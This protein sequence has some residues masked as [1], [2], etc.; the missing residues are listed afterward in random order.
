MFEKVVKKKITACLLENDLFNDNQHGFR[1]NRSCLSQLLCHYEEILSTLENGSCADV[2]Y[3]DFS[4]AFD[5]VNFEVLLNKLRQLG[6]GGKLGRWLVSFL[7]GRHQ[8]VSVIGVRSSLMEILSGVHVSVNS[9]RASLM[10]ILS[11][12]GPPRLSPG[13]PSIFDLY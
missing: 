11:G 13:P 1:S 7:V 9:V 4:K 6:I 8:H 3:L 10:E 5:K 2:I 12:V